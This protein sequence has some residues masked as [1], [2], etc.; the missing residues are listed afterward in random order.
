MIM[1]GMLKFKERAI[2]TVVTSA[3]GI[4]VGYFLS[5]NIGVVGIPLGIILV[6]LFSIGVQ[7]F[8]IN[9]GSG[10]KITNYIKWLGRPLISGIL[11]LFIFYHFSLSN[12]GL[13]GFAG[14]GVLLIIINISYMWLLGLSPK[15]RFVLS[16]RVIGQV[17]FIKSYFFD[18]A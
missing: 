16:S 8:F 11:L 13:I 2:S 10:I 15:H 4:S 7:Q 1:D 12:I 6:R 9:Q 18:K 17:N 5:K 14:C 3:F